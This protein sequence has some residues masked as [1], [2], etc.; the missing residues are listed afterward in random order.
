MRDREWQWYYDGPGEEG[1]FRLVCRWETVEGGKVVEEG[2]GRDMVEGRSAC[3]GGE[4]VFV[5]VD[6][7][8]GKAKVYL[9]PGWYDPEMVAKKE[10]WLGRALGGLVGGKSKLGSEVGGIRL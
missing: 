1:E 2:L 7:V 6:L 5:H 9:L 3:D 10:G 4:G 8:G